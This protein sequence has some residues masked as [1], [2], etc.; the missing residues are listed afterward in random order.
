MVVVYVDA[1]EWCIFLHSEEEGVEARECGGN[2]EGGVGLQE[3]VADG[4]V[5]SHLYAEMDGVLVLFG[6]GYCEPG[7]QC[8]GEDDEEVFH[9]FSSVFVAGAG[10]IMLFSTVITTPLETSTSTVWV[11]TAWILP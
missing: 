10:C 7:E 8:E 9:F 4:V 2:V 3:G 1:Q 11:S 6:H 5:S